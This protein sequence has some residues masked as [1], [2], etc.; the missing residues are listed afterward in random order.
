MKKILLLILLML[1]LTPLT[2]AQVIDFG[3]FIY[4]ETIKLEATP[5]SMLQERAWEWCASHYK[6]AR[7]TSRKKRKESDRI[8][9]NAW[10]DI[11]L[12]TQAGPKAVQMYYTLEI[13]AEEN[14]VSLNISNIHYKL[15]AD[16]V[17]KSESDSFT[18]EMIFGKGF[19]NDEMDMA[20]VE[21]Y[22]DASNEYLSQL[23]GSLKTAINREAVL[24]KNE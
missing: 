22:K 18:A 4:T 5:R 23:L 13:S 12:P 19:R 21:A 6:F 7:E 10:H 3:Q 17:F 15:Y 24:A 8:I 9:A 20:L 1:C 2:Q 14:Q 16:P 11:Y